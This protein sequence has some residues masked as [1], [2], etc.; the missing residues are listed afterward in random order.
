MRPLDH[1]RWREL[2]PLLDHALTLPE[3]A[4]AAWLEELRA[5]SP[6]LVVEL[7]ALLSTEEEADRRGFLA[8][9]PTMSL[10]GQQLGAYTLERPLGQGGMGSVWLARR[11]D[12]RFEGKAAVKLMN[13]ALLSPTGQERFRREGTALARLTHPGIARLLDAGVAPSGQPYL[14]I[15]YV[16]GQRIDAFAAARSLSRQERIGLVLQVLAAVGHAH[17][18]L[19][20]HRDIKPSNILVAADGSVK[21]LDF[22]IAK[23]LEGEGDGERSALTGDGGALTPDYAAPEQVRGEPVTTAT[24]VYACGVLLYLLL[25]GRHPTSGNTPSP[26]PAVAV[27]GVLDIEPP[28]LGLG[29]LDTILDKALRKAPGE[30]YQT[31]AALADDLR[32]YTRQEPVSARPD[33][34]AYRAR[35]FVRRNR[36][37]AA[38]AVVITAVLIGATVFS[39]RQMQNAEKQRDAAVRSARRATA[40]SQLQGVLAGDSRGPNGQP[41]TPSERIS[42]AEQILVR[43]FSGEPWLVADVMVDLSGNLG[44]NGDRESQRRMLARAGSI[45]RGANQ[46]AQLALAECFRSTSF[47]YDD[48]FDSAQAALREAQTA[49]RQAGAGADVSTQATCLEAEGKVQQAVGNGDSAVALLKRAAALVD[50]IATRRL[51]VRNALI[52]VLRLTGHSREAVPYQLSDL[53]ALEAAGYGETESFPNLASFLERLLADL[54]EFRAV[55][56]AFGGFIQARES[57]HGPGRVSTM[58]AFLYGQNKLRLGEVDSAERWLGIALRDTTEGAGGLANWVPAALVQLRLEQGRLGEARAAIRR[59]PGGLRGRR[60]I[61][62]MLRARLLRAEHNRAAA[63]TLLEGE[64]SALYRESPITQTLFTLPLVTAGEWRLEASDAGRADSLARL[65]RDAAALDSLALSKSALVGRAELLL[66]KSLH[67]QGN[68]PAA[69]EAAQ[70]ASVALSNGYG[71]INRW[72]QAARALLDSLPR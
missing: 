2:E 51:E 37:A 12:G 29:D 15:E 57:A 18:N 50:S 61:A 39:V 23:L 10:A 1:E 72:S 62:A 47:W 34:F 35:K 20:V 65:G 26:T 14:V 36:G 44:A 55:D 64:L 38:A 6:E 25:S 13:L 32:R 67:A 52:E 66:A 49:L 41:L 68:A 71:P 40:M 5:A 17:A 63:R 19:I 46:P 27:R 58:L 28:R 22:G 7:S 31:A 11:T 53:V 24:D 4:R 21:L 70:R 8:D 69:R 45:A 48:L 30:R 56:S 3:A 9:P 59:L 43:Q 33:S 54:G 16:D 42:L 60:A